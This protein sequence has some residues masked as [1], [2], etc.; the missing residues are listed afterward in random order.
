MEDK[1]KKALIDIVGEE[2]YT[3]K[4]IDLISYSKDASE[5]RHRPDAA[6]WPATAEEISAILK[7][8][9]KDKVPSRSSRGRDLSGRPGRAGERGRDSRPGAHE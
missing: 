8:A 4:L 9:N 1:T 2:N 6:V 7:L 3:D 5:H